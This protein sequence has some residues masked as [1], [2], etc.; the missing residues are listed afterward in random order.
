[1][2]LSH[3]NQQQIYSVSSCTSEPIPSCILDEPENDIVII[4]SESSFLP[5][6]IPDNQH[7]SSS[8]AHENSNKSQLNKK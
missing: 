3:D 7:V 8:I 1:V 2:L 6:N 5:S 4:S